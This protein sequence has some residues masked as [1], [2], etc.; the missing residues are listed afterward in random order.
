MNKNIPP[1]LVIDV[2]VSSA[3]GNLLLEQSFKDM[4]KLALKN[5][6]SAD[7]SGP[8]PHFQVVFITNSKK[9]GKFG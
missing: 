1:R 4:G 2:R 3:K 8:G 7:I 9:S 5:G 6:F